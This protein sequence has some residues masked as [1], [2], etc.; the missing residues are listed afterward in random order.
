MP[1]YAN[2]QTARN[3]FINLLGDS[4]SGYLGNPLMRPPLKTFTNY[5]ETLNS[6]IT[7]AGGAEAPEN[8]LSSQ[9]KDYEMSTVYISKLIT[10]NRDSQI[11]TDGEEFYLNELVNV[12][13]LFGNVH[14]SNATD[15]LRMA[16]IYPQQR[17]I[18]TTSINTSAGIISTYVTP[19]DY[20]SESTITIRAGVSYLELY[21]EKQVDKGSWC[22]YRSI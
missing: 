5:L 3:N 15:K 1:T 12:T 22:F 7:L 13:Q 18:T 19:E 21:A 2:H 14:A 11:L 8:I 17:S 9:I 4:N 6:E 16:T 20:F 10:N